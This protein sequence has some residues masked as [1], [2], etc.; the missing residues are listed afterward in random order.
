MNAADV[1]DVMATDTDMHPTS[2]WLFVNI[3][4]YM[5]MHSYEDAYRHECECLT[6]S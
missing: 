4:I 3:Y 1:I 2:Y 5:K 6:C